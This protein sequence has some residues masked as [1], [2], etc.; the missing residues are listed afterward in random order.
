MTKDE[1]FTVAERT[2]RAWLSH[3]TLITGEGF[4]LYC[5]KQNILSSARPSWWGNLINNARKYGWIVDTG[6][7]QP[8]VGLRS[9]GRRTPVWRVL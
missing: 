9:H 2:L 5:E 1:W 8:M 6:H 4:R 3:R 7:V